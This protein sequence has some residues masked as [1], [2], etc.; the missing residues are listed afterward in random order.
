MDPHI[1]PG[2]L[3]ELVRNTRSKHGRLS[4]AGG[5]EEHGHSRS[6]QVGRD[7]LTVPVASKKE[8]CVDG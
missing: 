7:H 3:S 1:D 2:L 6:H 4:D 5:P 8:Q